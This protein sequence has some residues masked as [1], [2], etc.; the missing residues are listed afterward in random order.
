M[1]ILGI[2]LRDLAHGGRR[3]WMLR[4]V[5]RGLDPTGQR[6]AHLVERRPMG[7]ILDEVNQF[8]RVAGK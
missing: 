1:P 8:V 4:P 2:P 5:A 3:A 7:R 6:A